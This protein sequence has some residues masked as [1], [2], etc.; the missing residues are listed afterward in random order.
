MTTVKKAP[1]TGERTEKDVSG[2]K[3]VRDKK[4]PKAGTGSGKK[5][6]SPAASFFLKILI[7]VTA[8]V[9]L[10]RFVFGMARVSG[11]SMYPSVRDGDLCIFFR[12]E[13]YH[14]GDIVRYADQS[15]QVRLGRITVM[16][17]E[18]DIRENR[19]MLDGAVISEDVV[20][21]TPPGTYPLPVNIGEG[22]YWIMNDFRSDTEDSRDFGPV[23]EKD[24]SGKVLFL[25]RR[26][27]F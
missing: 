9:I 6:L 15:G 17:G 19:P 2:E 4:V 20:Y 10:D 25:F 1:E 5:R 23:E 18:F 22:E 14:V 8:A 24:I 21:E 13:D 12:L 27:G 3:A 26:R 11:N 16:N 7:V